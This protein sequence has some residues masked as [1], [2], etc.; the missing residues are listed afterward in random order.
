MSE[1]KRGDLSQLGEQ[2][3]KRS[4]LAPW[5]ASIRTLGPR[6]RAR[7]ERHLQALDEHDRY[8][9][10]GYMANDEQ[11]H[12]YV[13]GLDFERDV[14]FG[15]YNRRLELIAMA[16]LA[17]ALDK[18]CESCA[19]FGVSVLKSARGH[20][21]GGKLFD[22]AVKHARNNGVQLMFIHALSENMAMLKIARKAGAQVEQDGSESRAYLRL[23]PATFDTIV[24]EM[25]E[26]KLAQTEYGL[27]RQARQ[28]W[29]FLQSLQEV[30]RGVREGRHKSS[31]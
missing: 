1:N 10:F 19:E 30:R 24:S 3:D 23:P 2:T 16:H 21:Y 26:E 5:V 11:I 15:I 22:R 18:H 12:R 20:G 9:R 29:D 4:R 25:I 13:Q 6:H 14:I 31:P 28:F 8:L 7:I 27:K 17:Y